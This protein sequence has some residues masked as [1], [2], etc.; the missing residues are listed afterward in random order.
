LGVEAPRAVGVL[1]APLVEARGLDA[2]AAVGVVAAR[3]VMDEDELELGVA[4]LE[5]LSE[6]VV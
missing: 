5:C 2:T 3:L 1:A 4:A 6:P